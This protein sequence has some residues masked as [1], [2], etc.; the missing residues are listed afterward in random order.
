MATF[1]ADEYLRCKQPMRGAAAGWGSS[2][3]RDTAAASIHDDL[4]PIYTLVIDLVTL[5]AAKQHCGF[6]EDH[7]VVPSSSNRIAHQDSLEA[8]TKPAPGMSISRHGANA[9]TECSILAVCGVDS[10]QC[11]FR[12]IRSRFQTAMNC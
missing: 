11:S 7:N 5:H 12:N 8:D 6:I 9:R 3:K 2:T 4:G 10:N 1:K